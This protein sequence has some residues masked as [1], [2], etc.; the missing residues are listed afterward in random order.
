M[1]SYN[2]YIASGNANTGVNI[3]GLEWRLDNA[4]FRSSSAPWKLSETDHTLTIEPNTA[5]NKRMLM[6]FLVIL[7]LITIVV[8]IVTKKVLIVMAA[9]V[10]I[11]GLVFWLVNTAIEK[12]RQKGP[13]MVCDFTSGTV[14]FHRAQLKVLLSQIAIW[15]LVTQRRRAAGDDQD[16]DVA[17]F[18]AIINDGASLKPVKLIGGFTRQVTRIATAVEART[19]ILCVSRAL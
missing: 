11:A 9:Y 5:G 2:D 3:T 14:D 19:K 10:A 17:S 13:W 1:I 6:F 4:S 15:Q 16:E 18:N 7:T 12:N 8:A